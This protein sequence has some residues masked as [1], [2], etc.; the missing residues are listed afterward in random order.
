MLLP[1]A[2][3][4]ELLRRAMELPPEA[5]AALAGSLLQSLESPVEAAWSTEIGRR[6]GQLDD[7]SA[8][9]VSWEDARRKITG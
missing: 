5:R 7:G 9:P 8:E 3:P 2:N 6:I 1:M 4:D